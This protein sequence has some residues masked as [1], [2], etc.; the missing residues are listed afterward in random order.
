MNDETLPALFKQLSI[1]LAENSRSFFKSHRQYSHLLCL[2]ALI[3]DTLVAGD[4]GSKIATV[5]PAA[6]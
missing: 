5:R 4:T 1:K 3:A 2:K 6:L